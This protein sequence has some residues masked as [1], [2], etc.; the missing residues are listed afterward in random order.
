MDLWNIIRK[1]KSQRYK[2]SVETLYTPV[3]FLF[4]TRVTSAS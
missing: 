3:L 1:L 4:F 2:T